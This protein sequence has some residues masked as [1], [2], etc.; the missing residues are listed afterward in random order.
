MLTILLM[1]CSSKPADTATSA[2]APSAHP[3]TTPEA[4]EADIAAMQAAIQT[5]L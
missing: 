1:A 5:S 3:Y 4:E 2:E